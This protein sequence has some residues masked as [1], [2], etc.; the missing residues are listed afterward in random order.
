MRKNRTNGFHRKGDYSDLKSIGAGINKMTQ[1]DGRNFFKDFSV[2]CGTLILLG[3]LL[4][5]LLPLIYIGFKI[6]LW[7]AIPIVGLLIVVILVAL[8]GRFISE[9]RKRW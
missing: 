4:L 8:F 3:F 5:V 2:G 1:K 9:A 7:L 6:A